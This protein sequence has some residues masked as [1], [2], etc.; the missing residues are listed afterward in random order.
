MDQ[1]LSHKDYN[2]ITQLKDPYLIASV[3]VRIFKFLKDPIIPVGTYYKLVNNIQEEN[4]DLKQIKNILSEIP[5]INQLNLFYLLHFM[6]TEVVSR[7]EVNKMTSYNIAAVLMPCLMRS[8]NPLGDMIHA[9]KCVKILEFII[10][11]CEEIA[12]ERGP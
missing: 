3:I 7:H 8:D 11:H 12:A 6:K 10:I 1:H 9:K 4:M 5:R 2:F